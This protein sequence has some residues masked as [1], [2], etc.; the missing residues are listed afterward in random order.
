MPPAT[1]VDRSPRR[2]LLPAG[3]LLLLGLA[4]LLTLTACSGFTAKVSRRFGGEVSIGVELDPRLNRDF[5][6]AVDFAIVYD[7]ELYG[8]LQKLTAD[9]WFSQRDQYRLDN[10][11]AKLEIHSWE[12]VPPCAGCAAPGT[13]VV[14]HRLGARGGVVFANYFNAGEHRI[15][16]EPLKAFSLRLGETEAELG[17]RRDR[18]QR[19]A[20]KKDAK[21]E[22][23]RSRRAKKK[24][25]KG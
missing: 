9:E 25:A 20:E 17:P 18:K 22:K 1:P 6:L 7:K 15:V 2:D 21:A 5:P 11:P 24:A 4:G 23:K 14:D 3:R 13:Q 19:K 16:I 10:E 8:E 12:W